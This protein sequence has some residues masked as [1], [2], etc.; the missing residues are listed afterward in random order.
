VSRREGN[1]RVKGEG[2]E[3]RDMKGEKESRVNNLR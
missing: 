1:N 3:E 2:R